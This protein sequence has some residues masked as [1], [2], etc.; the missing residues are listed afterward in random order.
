M[1][2]EA[3]QIREVRRIFGKVAPVYDLLNHVLS[4]GEDMRWRRFVARCLRPGPCGRVLDVACGTGDLSLA[5]ARR[6]GSPLVVGL[7][8]VPPMLGPALRK[9]AASKVKV[10][11]LCGDATRLPFGDACFDAVT[12]GFGIRNIPR[13][14][15]A[16]A[17][18]ARVLNPGGRL[19]VLEFTTPQG[20]VVERIY[21][22]YLMRFLPKIGGLISG[23]E[24]S[25]RYLAETIAEFPTPPKFR[26]EMQ[27]A[28]LHAPRSHALTRGIAWVHI[29][30]KI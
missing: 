23:D 17:E 6:P 8:L 4:L 24:A 18:M 27:A 28:G 16:M 22:Q 19:Y 26:S 20:P 15:E 25:Y 5:V 11:L 14:V 1:R 3:G 2:D 7:D 10:R 12:M 21:R 9:T 30:E 13:R 29:A